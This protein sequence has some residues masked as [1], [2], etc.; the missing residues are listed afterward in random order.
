MNYRFVLCTV[1]LLSL[2]SQ[3]ACSDDLADLAVQEKALSIIS[4]F[5]EKLC[6]SPPL[7]G[8][9]ENIQL[10]GSAK[11][12]LDT[13]VKQLVDMGIEGAAKYESKHY[14]GL[15]RK[16]LVSALKQSTDCKMEIWRD[17][18]DKMLPVRKRLP[19]SSYECPLKIKT[20]DYEKTMNILTATTQGDTTNVKFQ[21]LQFSARNK[22]LSR[23]TCKEGVIERIG[24][25]YQYTK[26]QC[27]IND[28]YELL[29]SYRLNDG[30]ACSCAVSIKHH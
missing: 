28:G 30:T 12:Q 17:L 18:K 8:S 15:L 2:W 7:E 13:I 27:Q 9:G 29:C 21:S 4:D 1:L 23:D 5:A 14:Q 22:T 24:P 3:S 11:A 19:T 20:A 26:S 25:N 6:K 16:D 10:T